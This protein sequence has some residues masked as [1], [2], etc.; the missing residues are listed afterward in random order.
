MCKRP[1]AEGMTD[2]RVAEKQ[3]DLSTQDELVISLSVTRIWSHL[4]SGKA[5]VS[6]FNMQL[7]LFIPAL[8]LL[9][10][11][12]ALHAN[13]GASEETYQEQLVIRSLNRGQISAYFQFRTFIPTS[14]DV[15][16]GGKLLEQHAINPNSAVRK[17][18]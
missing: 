9:L 16:Y 15:P 8:L 2:R 10:F 4:L 5:C 6:I 1:S 7:P 11:S 3:A 12:D 18:R 14:L 13:H 17:L